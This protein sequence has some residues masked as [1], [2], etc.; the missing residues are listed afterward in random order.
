MPVLRNLL[1]QLFR[2]IVYLNCWFED[3]LRLIRGRPPSLR[4]WLE[5]H[6]NVA[7]S[8]KWQDRFLTSAY[9][10]PEAAKRAW[11]N[12]TPVEK[13]ELA[14]AFEQAWDWMKA[15]SGTYAVSGESLAYPP[16]N[17]RDTSSDGG[18]PYTSVSKSYAR[19]FFI[20]WIAL[21]L[22]VEIGNR[23]PWSVTGYDD[24][25]L[26]VLFDSAAMMSRLGDDSFNLATGNAA[27]ANFVKRRDNL[28]HSL[29]A[30]PRYTYAFLANAG[31]PGSSKGETAGRLL[32]WIS[33]NLEHFY[34]AFTYRGAEEH[35]Q[36][37]GL[38][39]M[40]RIIEGTNNNSPGAN[41]QFG[42][43]TAGCHGT[44]GFIRNALRAVNIPV[45]I[46][47]LCLHSQAYFLTEDLY[48]DHGDNPYN[49]AFKATGLPASS[50]LIDRSTYQSWFGTDTVNRSVGCDKI[51]KQVS[52]LSRA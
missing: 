45:H 28:G 22:A 18:A 39:P 33:A 44:T 5:R 35:W 15:Q 38:P 23:V 32:Q 4:C 24:E 14:D 40:T 19:D 41:G 25:Q 37:R 31:I 6:A 34:G 42:H 13:G 16:V 30:P 8:I 7:N 17:L 36:F 50:L 27:H 2:P 26:Q 46:S 10:I 3:F 9:D 20:R 48:L 21:Q 43:W 51:G 12:W 49:L 1:E 52:V 11:P 47:T 29:I